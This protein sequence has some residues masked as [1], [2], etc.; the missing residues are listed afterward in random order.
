[1]QSMMES[2]TAARTICIF[3]LSIP[4]VLWHNQ[5][6]MIQMRRAERGCRDDQ[7]TYPRLLIDARVW[8][9]SGT[10]SREGVR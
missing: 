2:T 10:T 1:M 5:V 8:K 4:E 7:G 9:V 3:L 6:A